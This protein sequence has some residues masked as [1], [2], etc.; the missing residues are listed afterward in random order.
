LEARCDAGRGRLPNPHGTH[1]QRASTF[2]QH[3]LRVDGSSGGQECCPTTTLLRCS[4]GTSCPT[5]AHWSLCRFLEWES[6]GLNK[7]RLVITSSR[8]YDCCI[9]K[10]SHVFGAR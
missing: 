7:R 6:P 8:C 10:Y 9:T 1:A 4:C 2:Q 5:P 3:P